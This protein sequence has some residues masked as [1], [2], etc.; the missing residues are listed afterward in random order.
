MNT[1]RYDIYCRNND[2]QPAIIFRFSQD[3]S[4]ISLSGYTFFA[5]VRIGDSVISRFTTGGGLSV[6]SNELKWSFGN[7]ITIPAGEYTYAVKYVKDEKP[8]TFIAGDF[9]VLPEEVAH[10]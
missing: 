10:V 9:K 2:Y 8:M 6:Y 1:Y 3:G 7:Q 4:A 5:E